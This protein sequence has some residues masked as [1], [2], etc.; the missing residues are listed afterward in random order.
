[1][2]PE[3][4]REDGT[5]DPEVAQNYPELAEALKKQREEQQ[6]QGKNT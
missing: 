2:H 5:L 1:V 3:L 6:K 4:L